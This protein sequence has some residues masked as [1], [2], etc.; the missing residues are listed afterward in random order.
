M[1]DC[2]NTET[3]IEDC[4]KDYYKQDAEEMEDYV[5]EIEDQDFIFDKKGLDF[6][7]DFFNEGSVFI[8]NGYLA[9]KIDEKVIYFHREFKK[10]I[11]S[12]GYGFVVHHKNFK[13]ED[14]RTCNLRIMSKEEHDILHE[15][16]KQKIQEK[17]EARGERMRLQREKAQERY[18]ERGRKMRER[19]E[20]RGERMRAKWN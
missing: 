11:K 3:Y 15:K 17:Y 7:N 20:A 2:N 6:F 14:N 18:E 5:M 1:E 12:I 8:H 4:M 9:K 19:Y 10:T 13:K 16:R